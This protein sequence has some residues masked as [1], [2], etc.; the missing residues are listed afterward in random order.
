MV[1]K[2]LTE[3]SV[4]LLPHRPLRAWL[5]PPLLLSE[6]GGGNLLPGHLVV[7]TPPPVHPFYPDA[8]H[9]VSPVH[10]DRSWEIWNLYPLHDLSVQGLVV[11]SCDPHHVHHVHPAVVMMHRVRPQDGLLF[12]LGFVVVEVLLASAVKISASGFITRWWNWSPNDCSG[13]GEQFKVRSGDTQPWIHLVWESIHILLI[14]Q[15]QYRFWSKV[16]VIIELSLIEYSCVL[17]FYFRC[18]VSTPQG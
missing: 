11:C 17:F 3:V 16:A 18:Q 2:K 14:E 6:Q 9:L 15:L 4:L 13:R 7:T 8:A 1:F 5:A 10:Q 12:V